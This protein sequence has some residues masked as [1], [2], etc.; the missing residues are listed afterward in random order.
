MLKEAKKIIDEEVTYPQGTELVSTTDKRGIITYANEAFCQVAGYSKEE[1]VGKNHNIVRHPD[2]PKAAFKDLWDNLEAKKAWRGAVKNRCKD[3]RYYWVDAFVTPIYEKD[4]LVGYQSVR[5]NLGETEK[6]RAVELYK[7]VLKSENAPKTSISIPSLNLSMPQKLGMYALFNLILLAATILASPYVAVLL[8]L[9]PFLFFY[10]DILTKPLFAEKLAKE[11]DSVSR[12]VFC[13][14]A[15]NIPEYHL[16]MDEGRFRTVIG[17][18]VDSCKYLLK[19]ADKLNQ[20]SVVATKNIEQEAAELEKVAE[21]MEQ[22]VETIAGIAESSDDTLER[23][24]EAGNT[25]QQVTKKLSHTH[26]TI[27]ALTNEV[28]TSAQITEELTV[29]SEKINGMMAEI[30]GIADQTNLLA[31]NAAIEAARAGE[32]GRGFAV[33]ADEVRALSQRTQDATEQIQT[34]IDG[35][36]QTLRALNS[37]MERGQNNA[38]ECVDVTNETQSSLGELCNII[39]EIADNATQV[40]AAAE[41]QSIVAMDICKNI[42]NIEQTSGS[43]LSQVQAIAHNANKIEQQSDKLMSLGKSFR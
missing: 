21:A 15:D 41:E 8:P 31:L 39:T 35:I 1:L 5:C 25:A 43:N 12:L 40:S 2:M 14:D 10:S 24:N 36:Q 29:E 7:K 17:R 16:K 26:T 9:L 23:T 28:R 27:D 19:D 4:V 33:V 13:D 20:S 3:G 11:Y 6:K 32:Q 18:V 34:S 22:M 38:R 37:T 42:D 30:K